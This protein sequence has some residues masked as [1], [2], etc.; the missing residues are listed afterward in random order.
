MKPL[1]VGLGTLAVWAA[2][3]IDAS[4]AWNNVYQPTLFGRWRQ[5]AATESYY[6]APAVV[7]APVAVAAPA[8]AYAAPAASDP[9]Q[10]QQ[11]S[12]SYTQRCFYEPVTTYQTQSYYEP[13]TTYRTSYYYEPVTSYRYSCYY[14]PCTCTTQQVA[15]PVTSYQLRS[16]CC[17]VQSWVQRCAQVP[18][19]T[20]RKSC[21]LQPQ[22][23]CC[24]TTTGAL[25]PA[26][27]AVAAPAYGNGAYGN[28][29]PAYGNPPSVIVT[30]PQGAPQSQ[31]P[32]V[33]KDQMAPSGPNVGNMSLSEQQRFAFP[34]A[35]PQ[36][37]APA[38]QT[39]A[40]SQY[41]QV[42]LDR[43]VF[44]PESYVEGQIVRN[45]NTPRP[46]ASVL[47]VSADNGNRQSVTANTAG[48]FQVNLA[49]GNWLVYVQNRDGTAQFHS[50]LS[51]QEQ[52]TA[53]IT[54]VN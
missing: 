47:F 27:G 6:A 36:W 54:L 11:C 38:K 30:P 8:V 35:Q 16:K 7:A 49:S 17:P 43:I 9:C 50:R 44:G 41:P 2:T 32:P 42:K 52:Q 53:R 4:A 13:V 28:G 46:N 48:R 3:A 25:I 10:Q 33:I 34:A 1:M 23:T 18:V 15:T 19:T 51:V 21:Y 37:Q 29:A 5:R 22:T 31:Q 12:T 26:G 24:T 20:Y 45:D 40:P 14:D 39:P